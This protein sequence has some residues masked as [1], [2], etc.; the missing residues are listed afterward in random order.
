[1]DI[2]V[3]GY[4]GWNSRRALQVINEVFPKNVIQQPSLIIVY[5]GGNDCMGPHPSGL[6]PHVPLPEYIDNIKRIATYL[7]DLSES[8]HLIFLSCP[9]VNEDMLSSASSG[10]FS[11]LVRTNEACRLYSEACVQ[12]CKEMDVKVIDLWSAIQIRPDWRT[13]CFTD[14]IH[15]SS[16]GSVIVVEEILKV[17][18]GAEWVP[19]LHWKNMPTEF[20]KSSPFDLVASDMKSTVNISEFTFHREKQWN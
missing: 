2:L 17:L 19:S 10:I 7:Q 6:G 11:P 15:F 9:P 4:S 18:N 8:T 13:A 5:F 3:R 16:E 1:A 14:G 12:V 20:S